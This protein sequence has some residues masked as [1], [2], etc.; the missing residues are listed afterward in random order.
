M[1][2]M[3]TLKPKALTPASYSRIQQ[4]GGS[5]WIGLLIYQKC[6]MKP[7]SYY[8]DNWLMELHCSNCNNR[9]QVC[10]LYSSN[11]KQFF[12]I[13]DVKKHAIQYSRQKKNF[14]QRYHNQKKYKPTI[15]NIT[16]YLKQ[17]Q[18]KK[19]HPDQLLLHFCPVCSQFMQNQRFFAL[20]LLLFVQ[21]QRFLHFICF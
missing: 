2:K 10:T 11:W 6:Q 1:K 3:A 8:I 16:Q 17:I 5:F 15:L 4:A 14:I 19:L 13:S 12:S 18:Q 7:T 20:H 21:N 9:Y